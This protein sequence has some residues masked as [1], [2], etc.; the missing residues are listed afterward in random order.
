MSTMSQKESRRL[1][2]KV[3]AGSGRG[4]GGGLLDYFP[5]LRGGGGGINNIPSRDIVDSTLD[6]H[7]SLNRIPFSTFGLMIR[8]Q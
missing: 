1:K 3:Y 6:L 7:L 5:G 4:G 8:P 2:L